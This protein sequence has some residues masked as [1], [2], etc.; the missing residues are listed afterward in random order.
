MF[1]AKTGA[2]VVLSLSLF[3]V[4][5]EAFA[6]EP[7]TMRQQ[8]AGIAAE[9]SGGG[10]QKKLRFLDENGDGLNDL[11]RDSDGDGVPD[12]KLCNGAGYGGGRGAFY[13]QGGGGVMRNGAGTGGFGRGYGNG[14]RQGGGRR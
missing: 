1:V 14:F 5:R 9:C 7:V 10:A 11:V 2:F 8:P 6:D 3:S 12:G 4:T 13:W